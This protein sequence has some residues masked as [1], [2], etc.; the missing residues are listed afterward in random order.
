[1]ICSLIT[2]PISYL[3]SGEHQTMNT[4]FPAAYLISFK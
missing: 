2:Y 4:L 1:V 3:L